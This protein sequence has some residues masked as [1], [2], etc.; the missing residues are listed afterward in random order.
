MICSEL[1]ELIRNG[2]VGKDWV[3]HIMLTEAVREI[4]FFHY[5][6]FILTAKTNSQLQNKL[7]NKNQNQYTKLILLYI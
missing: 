3:L 4:A 2:V 6:M 1:E 5:F 7:I